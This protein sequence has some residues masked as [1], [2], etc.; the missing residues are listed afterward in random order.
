[1]P[2][3]HSAIRTSVLPM[4][5]SNSYQNKEASIAISSSNSCFRLDVESSTIKAEAMWS[6]FVAKPHLAFLSRDKSDKIFKETF[7]DSK[8]AIMFACGHTKTT[9]IVKEAVSPN[10][11]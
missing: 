6:L 1:M 10:F 3:V 5:G 11:H 8:V 4:R 2:G 9:T 7:P